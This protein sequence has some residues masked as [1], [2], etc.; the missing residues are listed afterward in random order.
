M[1]KLWC[2]HIFQD[3]FV[4]R[5]KEKV[6]SQLKQKSFTPNVIASSIEG[7]VLSNFAGVWFVVYTP[8]VLCGKSY[9]IILYKYCFQGL[10]FRWTD[11]NSL[12]SH[13]KGFNLRNLWGG[14][15]RVTP[16]LLSNW[17]KELGIS[18]DSFLSSS[19]R[20]IQKMWMHLSTCFVKQFMNGSAL[21]VAGSW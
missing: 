10:R 15:L 9:R 14:V 2:D 17:L 11:S 21:Q 20:L 3:L 7:G 4:F 5:E 19:Y 13:Y 12:P 18:W 16:S 6:I 1:I 8:H